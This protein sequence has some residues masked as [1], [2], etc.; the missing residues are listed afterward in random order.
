MQKPPDRVRRRCPLLHQALVL[1]FF[2]SRHPHLARHGRVATVVGEKRA[3]HPVR[4]VLRRFAFRL[5][6]RLAGSGTTVSR[7]IASSSRPERAFPSR[8]PVRPWRHDARSGPAAHRRPRRRSRP[9]G[10][11]CLP[12]RSPNSTG[13]AGMSNCSSSGSGN[14][15]GSSPSSGPPR[16]QS[17][18]RSGSRCRSSSWLPSFANA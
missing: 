18:P 6:G 3:H 1:L 16:T 13:P 2:D 7:A 17:K 11:S 12:S 15:S 5:T 9:P 10:S 4:S 8:E 14:I